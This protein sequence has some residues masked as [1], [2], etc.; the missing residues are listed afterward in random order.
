MFH[1][2]KIEIFFQFCKLNFRRRAK[3]GN[4]LVTSIKMH[5]KHWF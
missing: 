1:F 2:A 5:L 3:I 4:Q